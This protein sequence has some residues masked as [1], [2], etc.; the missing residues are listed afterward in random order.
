ML[1]NQGVREVTLL[2]QNV[3]SFA[4]LS[5]AQQR[6]A[7]TASGGTGTGAASASDPFA[8]YAKVSQRG[9]FLLLRWRAELSLH[10][11]SLLLGGG[12]TPALQ[13]CVTNWEA[14]LG[15]ARCQARGLVR[16]ARILLGFAGLP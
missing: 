2:G 8:V 16:V 4:D 1:S 9:K 10:P 13:A 6:L 11:A 7:A 3:N 14:R 5:Q 15:R 12:A